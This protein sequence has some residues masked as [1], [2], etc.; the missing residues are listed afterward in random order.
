MKLTSKR[1]L[2]LFLVILLSIGFGLGFDAVATAVERHRHPIPERYGALIEEEAKA[3]GVPPAIILAIV[4]CESEFIS[5]TVS[6]SGEIGLMQ[7]SPALL[8]EVY[9]ELLHE[10]VPDSGILY[11]PKTNL[12]VGTAHL[13]HLYETYGVWE[14]AYAAWHTDVSTVDGWLT[15]HLDEDGQLRE[16]PD[17]DTGKFVARVEKNVR[18]YTKLYF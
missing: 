7:I 16:I 18:M 12:R 10:P 14:I 2:I 8:E 5:N 3:F 13:A 4:N 9:T 17:K 6:E 11:D 1:L 15:E